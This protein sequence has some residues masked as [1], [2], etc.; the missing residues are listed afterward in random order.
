MSGA[1]SGEVAFNPTGG[2]AQQVALPT[3]YPVADVT[4]VAMTDYDAVPVSYCTTKFMIVKNENG[5]TDYTEY[6]NICSGTNL[7]TYSVQAT[8]PATYWGLVVTPTSSNK[9]FYSVTAMR[10][11]R[12]YSS[13]A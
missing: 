7:G 9:T 2:S 8:G 4:V 10:Y 13:I 3:Y 11:K 1:V 5:G 6:T 12:P